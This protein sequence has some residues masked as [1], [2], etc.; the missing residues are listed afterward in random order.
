M[1]RIAVLD[2]YQGAVLSL[3]CWARLVGRAAVDVFRDT[4]ASEAALAG[5]LRPYEIV[6]AIRERTRFTASLLERLPG[7]ELLA[8]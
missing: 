3:P 8:L 4:P 6:V 1:K 7:L 5:R 2:D